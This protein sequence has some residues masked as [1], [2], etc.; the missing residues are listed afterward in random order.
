MAEVEQN[1]AGMERGL[2]IGDWNDLSQINPWSFGWLV[3]RS[4]A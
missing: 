1:A 2:K 3:L 4:D